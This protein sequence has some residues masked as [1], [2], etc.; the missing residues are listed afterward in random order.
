MIVFRVPTVMDDGNFQVDRF[1]DAGEGEVERPNLPVGQD[2][3]NA[4]DA[5][6]RAHRSI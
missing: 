2:T 4:A 1:S 5:R 3:C 6:K